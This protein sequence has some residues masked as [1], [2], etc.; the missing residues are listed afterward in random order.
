MFSQPKCPKCNQTISRGAKFCPHCGQPL[1][2][3]NV[4]CGAC[5]TDNRA[6]ASF[7]RSC[8]RPLSQSAAPEISGNHWAR[9][10]EDFAT[11]IEVQDLPGILRRGLI[12]EPG[13]NALLIEGGVGRGIVPPGEYTLTSLPR[14]ISDWFEGRTPG[15]ATALLISITPADLAFHL[16]GRF[17]SDPLPIGLTLRLRVE[18]SDPGKFL[19]NVLKSRERFS[20]DDLREYLYPEVVQAADNWLRKHTLQQLVDEA[21]L[22][23]QLELAVEDALRL[24]FAQSGLHF[25]QV[26]TAELNLEPYDEVKGLRGQKQLLI[27]RSDAEIDLT[28]TEAEVKIQKAQADIDARKRLSEI[29]HEVNLLA[30]T[31]ET[32]KIE[33]EERRFELNQRM[34]QA[35]MSDRMN[36]VRTDADFERFMNDVDREK[37]LREK[38]RQDLQRIWHEESEDHNRARAHMLALL[39]SEQNFELRMKEIKQRGNLSDA[40]LD[41]EISLVRKRADFEFEQKRRVV[42]EEVKLEQERLKLAEARAQAELARERAQV[43]LENYKRDAAR[44]QDRDDALLAMEL[45]QKMKEIR[46]AEEE[47]NLRIRRVDEEERLRMQR[48]HQIE[49]QRAQMELEAQRFELELRARKEEHDF[50]LRRIQEMGRLGT[51][52]LVALSGT[53]QGK[54]LADLK[55]TEALKGMSEEQILAA[56]AERSPEVARAIAE[57]YRALAEGQGSERERELYE[58]LL[59]EQNTALQMLREEHDKRARERTEEADRNRQTTERLVD[60]LSETAQAFAKGSNNQPV[61]VVPGQGAPQVYPGGGGTPVNGTTAATKLCPNCGQFVPA[62]SRHCEHCGHKFE[63]VA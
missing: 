44:N 8:G 20:L 59:G 23:D 26:R 24:T 15:T 11:R 31:E 62:N 55:R 47:A 10:D 33:L 18:V 6:S 63:G 13:T 38:E 45:L 49:M 17:T 36:S 25:M 37:L 42:E 41:N 22:K 39:E 27:Y 7:C 51:E 14:Q 29:Q 50:E 21:G 1:D 40:E 4:K 19:L 48:V 35:V 60:R 57:R 32:R 16:G 61:I 5:G 3:G 30:L 12:V 52:A 58:R 43:E 9:R 34:R 46:A 2:S 54:I 56:A 28:K 53:E